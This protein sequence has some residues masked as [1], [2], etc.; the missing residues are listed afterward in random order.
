MIYREI[1]RTCANSHIAE[2][3]VLSLGGEIARLLSEDAHRV[4]MSRGDYAALLVR[5]FAQNADAGE[6]DRVLNATRG[7]QQPILSGL[8]YI[9][10]RP[11]PEIAWMTGRRL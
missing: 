3:A 9:L 4:A 1:V 8:R 10:E 5:D 6:K 7:S 2:A 11:R